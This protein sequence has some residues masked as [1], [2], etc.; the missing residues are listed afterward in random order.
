MVTQLIQK[1]LGIPVQ[2]SLRKRGSPV[3]LNSITTCG[4][5]LMSLPWGERLILNGEEVR[6]R[7]CP[8]IPE[9]HDRIVLVEGESSA[10]RWSLGSGLSGIHLWEVRDKKFYLMACGRP[11]RILGEGPV[12]ANWY[13]G[14]LEIPSGECLVNNEHLVRG[15]YAECQHTIIVHV[16]AGNVTSIQMM[17]TLQYH[18]KQYFDSLNEKLWWKAWQTIAKLFCR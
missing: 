5:H 13:S 1:L 4:N 15:I 18:D 10:I 7:N 16:N 8:K 3:E 14:I 12:F 2:P 11:Y 17:D 6:M 9:D